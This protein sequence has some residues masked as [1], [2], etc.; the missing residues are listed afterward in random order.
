LDE[1]RKGGPQMWI[2]TKKLAIQWGLVLL[3]II[4]I[5]VAW[6]IWGR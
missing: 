1:N 6:E 2:L 3:V 5:I 4:G